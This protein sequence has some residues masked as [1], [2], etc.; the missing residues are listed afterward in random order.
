MIQG[1]DI[2]C[3]VCGKEVDP[4]TAPSLSYRDRV[5]FFKCSRCLERFTED[6]ERFVGA[7]GHDTHGSCHGGGH[8]CC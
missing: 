5:Y 7:Q 8:A 1:D 6:P 4:A 2:R 3:P